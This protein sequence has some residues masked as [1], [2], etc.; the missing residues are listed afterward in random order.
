MAAAAAP[1]AA[2][3][4]GGGGPTRDTDPGAGKRVTAG[5]RQENNMAGWVVDDARHERGAGGAGALFRGPR[6]MGAYIEHE[7]E[8]APCV[9][10]NDILPA[11]LCHICVT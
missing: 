4:A 1:A 2:P 3:G 7:R 11:V 8:D 10:V 6:D 9:F 5:G